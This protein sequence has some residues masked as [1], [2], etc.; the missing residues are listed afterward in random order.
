[1]NYT[2]LADADRS[3]KSM[4]GFMISMLAVA[5]VV[6]V[7]LVFTVISAFSPVAINTGEQFLTR[8]PSQM[9]VQSCGT[10]VLVSSDGTRFD[11]NEEGVCPWAGRMSLPFSSFVNAGT[12]ITMTATDF[13]HPAVRVNK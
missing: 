13:N 5:A 8:G 3:I 12:T 10:V 11:E 9:N 1:M 2:P 7:L 4:D 6:A